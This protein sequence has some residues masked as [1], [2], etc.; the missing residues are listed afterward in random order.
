MNTKMNIEKIAEIAHEINRAYCKSIG[1][2]SQVNWNEASDHQKLSAI[3]G[4]KFHQSS[5]DALPNNSH[6]SWM[7]EKEDAGWVYGEEKNEELKTHPC[8]VPYE[9]LPQKQ[10]SKDYIFAAVVNQLSK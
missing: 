5:N 7:K 4:V 8:M 3:M 10:Q 9:D 6:N 1:D 2:L